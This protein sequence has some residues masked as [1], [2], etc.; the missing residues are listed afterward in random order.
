VS[1]ERG[2]TTDSRLRLVPES[3][4]RAARAV[5]T[6]VRAVRGA[7]LQSIELDRQRGEAVWK[8]GLLA[9]GG[10]EHDVVIDASTGEERS[11][12]VDD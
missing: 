4:V 12:T 8:A 2:R 9:E 1:T 3:T 6:A 7:R 10:V 5:R 11:A